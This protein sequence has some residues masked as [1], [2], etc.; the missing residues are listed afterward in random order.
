MA[1]GDKLLEDFVLTTV[2]AKGDATK[3]V[4]PTVNLVVTF[5]LHSPPFLIL[6]QSCFANS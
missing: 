5:L 6:V 1:G 4:V 3:Y 2:L